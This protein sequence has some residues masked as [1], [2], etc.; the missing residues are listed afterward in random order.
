MPPICSF[1]Q[2]AVLRW[3]SNLLVA[4]RW[5]APITPASSDARVS[6]TICTA[7]QDVSTKGH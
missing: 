1:T 4:K 3:A 7:C 2:P 5:P 6:S